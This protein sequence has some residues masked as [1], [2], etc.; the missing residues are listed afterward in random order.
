MEHIEISTS[1]IPDKKVNLLHV[2]C[3]ELHIFCPLVM[4]V[5]N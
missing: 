2:Y 3:P 1:L 4:L 5:V